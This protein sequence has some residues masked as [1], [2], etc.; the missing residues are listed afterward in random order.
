MVNQEKEI[1]KK[2]KN[3]VS[4]EGITTKQLEIG[5]WYVEHKRQLKLVLIGFLILISAAFWA[6]GLYGF[7]YYIARGMNDD[8]ILIKELVQT[9]SA[10]H[11]Y[12]KQVSAKG[13]AIA[14][15]EILRPSEGKYDL[16]GKLKNDNPKWWAEFD[17]YFMAAGRPTEKVKG[18]ILPE[19]IRYLTAL[20]Q[21]LPYYPADSR[22]IIENISWRRI[23]RHQI[24]DWPAYRASHLEIAS[25]EIK[26]IPAR[27]NP[28]SEKLGLNQLS[29]KAINRTAYNYWSVGFVILLYAGDQITGL[30]HYAL[31]DFMSGQTR[32]VEISW[33]GD[34]GRPDRVEIIPEINIMK[35]DIYIKYDGGVGQEK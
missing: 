11:D 12:I 28:L 5:L 13:L 35:D 25:A 31:N 7:A 26:F 20:A 29:F 1:E 15:V 33:P 23:N 27:D 30:N 17:Y 6:Y 32:L 18:Y 16:Y 22:L 19:E 8:E 4:T 24:A 21:A 14:P 3:Y 34:F 10:G 9:N 2:V